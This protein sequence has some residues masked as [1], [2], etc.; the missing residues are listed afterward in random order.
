M[1]CH[2]RRLCDVNFPQETGIGL[3]KALVCRILHRFPVLV[4]DK[5]LVRS[6][7]SQNCSLAKFLLQHGANASVLLPNGTSLLQHAAASHQYDFIPMLMESGADPH[8]LIQVSPSPVVVA[9]EE[10][11]LDVLYSVLRFGYRL[12]PKMLE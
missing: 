12:L 3:G 11:N 6:V 1:F 5:V 9:S 2:H 7:S 10:Q 8:G 4:H